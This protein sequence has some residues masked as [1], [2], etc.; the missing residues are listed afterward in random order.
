MELRKIFTAESKKTSDV[1]DRGIGFYIP[2]Y[3]REYD[4]DGSHIRRLFEDITHG[5]TQLLHK[6]KK[7]SITFIGTLIVVDDVRP[8]TIGPNIFGSDMPD[9]ILSIIDGQQRLTTIVLTNIRLHDEI[10]MR[11]DALLKDK[12]ELAFEWLY[13]RAIQMVDE[14]QETFE[15]DKRRPES[16]YRWQPRMIRAY[17]DLWARSEHE[18]R[19]E[20]PIAAFVHGYSR[21]IHNED[22]S[23]ANELYTGES[24]IDD[25]DVLWKNYVEIQNLIEMVS[26]GGEENLGALPLGRVAEDFDFQEAVLKEKFPEN[27]CNILSNESNDDFKELIRLVFF[28]NFLMN[29]VGVTVVSAPGAYAFEMFESLNTTGEE[30][31]IF[32]TFRPRVIETER[33]DKYEKSDSREYMGT[34]EKYFRQ[35]GT[36]QERQKETERLLIPFALAESG[37]KLSTDARDQRQYMRNQYESLPDIQEKRNFVRHLSHVAEFMTN[38]WQRK[39]GAFPDITEFTESERKVVL[40]CMGVL[41]RANP[42]TI[43]PLVRFYSQVLLAPSQLRTKA[44]NELQE[45]VKAMSAFFALLRGSGRTTGNLADQY[46]DLMEKGFKDAGI[47]PF[48]R[49]S[50]VQGTSEF[51]T[52]EKLRKALRCVLAKGRAASIKSKKDWV[53]LSAERAVYKVSQP[54]TRFL[55]FASIHDTVED[56]KDSA[57]PTK[58]RPEVLEMLTW[59]KWI[60]DLTIEHVA[61]QEPDPKQN[62][63]PKSLYENPNLIDCLGNLTLLPKSENSSFK[64][65]PWRAK[66]EMYRVLSLP[67]QGALETHLEK[68]EDLE[69]QLSD[70]T[71]DLLIE[72]RYL[73]HLSTICNVEEW[74]DEL[75]QKRS[76]RLVKLV[77]TNIAPWLGFD[78]E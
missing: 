27:V 65:R 51:L 24:Y 28:A 7:D 22:G 34:I 70:K 64:N 32:E 10:R 59:E 75:V 4:W 54:L 71:K 21:R 33:L 31:T 72:G 47:Q 42:V 53:R 40:M 19:Y 16:V 29:R 13:D 62:D 44:V 50:S 48:S 5:L 6:E 11:G 46:R 68:L 55:L 30:L 58:G 73:K 36:A 14:L 41:G 15:E 18:A 37:K 67:T 1:L 69:I 8:E 12:D 77:W 17:V 35:F 60:S 49:Y 74:S 78:D 43:G 66:K 45:A 61:P 56:E 20:S 3:Q 57:L 52:A 76:R 25:S 9:K 63:W 38:A 23:S 2:P 26:N 39:E